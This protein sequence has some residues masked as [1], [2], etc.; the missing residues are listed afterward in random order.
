MPKR[1]F[2]LLLTVSPWRAWRARGA[3]CSG[4]PPRGRAR[5]GLLRLA[6]VL[7]LALAPRLA[8]GCACGCGIF[9]VGASSLMASDSDSGW[10]IWLRYT[11]MNQNQNWEGT[12]QAPAADNHDKDLKT[13]FYFLGVQYMFSRSWGMMLELPVLNRSLTTTDDGTVFGPAGSIYTG[14][15]TDFGDLQIMGLY[16]GLSPDMSTALLFGVKL[17]TGNYTGPTGP[18]GGQEIDR[19]TL[20]GSGSTDLMV[21]GYHVGGLRADNRLAYYVQ[22]RYQFAVMTRNEYRPGN[23]FDGAVGLTYDLGKVGPLT[24]VAPVVSLLGSLRAADSGQNADPPNSGYG[25]LVIAPGID[26]RID[27]VKF[28]ADVELPVFQHVNAASSL[29]VEGNSGQLVTPGAIKLQV[30]YDF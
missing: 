28:Y 24:K 27:K 18:L 5:R 12:S 15:I 10:S 29:A 21:G 23:E 4:R 6:A 1:N 26:F 8:W 14:H 30:G 7:L 2:F 11:Y 22:A 3:A 13:N 9:D 20:P 25:R 19:D 17:P 16:T